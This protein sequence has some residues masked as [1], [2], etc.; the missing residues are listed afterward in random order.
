MKGGISIKNQYEYCYFVNNGEF[1]YEG[2]ILK[3]YDL[4]NNYLGN[5]KIIKFIKH[6]HRKTKEPYL[7]VKIWFYEEGKTCYQTFNA[8]K[9]GNMFTKKINK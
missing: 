8:E 2:Q 7:C 3:Y 5:V 6:Y 9:L 4:H 1:F